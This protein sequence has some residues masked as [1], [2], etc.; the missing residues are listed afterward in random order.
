MTSAERPER[1]LLT[2]GAGQMAT[3]L[4]PRLRRPERILR[5]IDLREPRQAHPDDEVVVGSLTD[6][7]TLRR[8]CRDVDAVVHLGGLATEAAWD[9]ILATNV[10]GTH[11][12]LR[13]CSELGV[14]KVILASSN[15]AVG[16]LHHSG[17]P[18]PANTAP[19]PD[20]YYGFSKA[21]IEMLGL[22]FH[23]R[24]GID[25]SCLRIGRCT[26]EPS[27]LRALVN[28]L[29]P[30]DAGRLVEACLD[31]DESGYRII[32][33]VSNNTRGWFDLSDGRAIGYRPLDDSER[34]AEKVG[35]NSADTPTERDLVGG[36]F[37]TRPLGVDGRSAPK[38]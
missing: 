7:S 4:R 30:D 25:V 23:Q 15:H 27:N 17:Q 37:A 29:S 6:E 5:L 38:R 14:P 26:E 11:G 9:D 22:L 19:Q 28:W 31:C 36:H 21:A 13:I 24:F 35:S 18:I 34:F 16:L 3:L 1:V 10:D 20:S 2:G 12:L 33:G 8:A 32:W